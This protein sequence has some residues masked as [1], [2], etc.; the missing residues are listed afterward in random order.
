MK[1]ILIVLTL[2]N[3]WTNFTVDRLTNK[4]TN[5]QREGHRHHIKLIS[6]IFLLAHLILEMLFF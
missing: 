5:R 1:R 2:A 3:S 4:Q 6:L